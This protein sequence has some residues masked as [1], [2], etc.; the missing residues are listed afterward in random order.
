MIPSCVCW[1]SWGRG[2]PAEPPRP[3]AGM[4]E[5][6]LEGLARLRAAMVA[7]VVVLALTLLADR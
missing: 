2:S 5:Q 3:E 4:L 7:L 1:V 6:V